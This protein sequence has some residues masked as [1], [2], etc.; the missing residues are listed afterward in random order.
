MTNG[1]L[2]NFMGVF[3][4]FLIPRGFST[5][6]R[7]QIKELFIFLVLKL[8]NNIIQENIN[9]K[10]KNFVAYLIMIYLFILI[11][12]LTGMVPYSIT[13]TSLLI[14][15]FFFSVTIFIGLNILGTFFNK[16]SS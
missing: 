13:I 9:M 6:P 10:N 1:L 4:L 12:N 16:N 14:V 7:L 11:S 2:L 3:V 15:S 8:L 5:V